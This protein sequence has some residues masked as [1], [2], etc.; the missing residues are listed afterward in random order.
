[1]GI[2]PACVLP[3]ALEGEVAAFSP[4]YWDRPLYHDVDLAFFKLVGGG[5]ARS[6]SLLDFLNP[7][8]RTQRNIR[9]SMGAAKALAIDGNMVGEHK[10]LKGGLAVLDGS[11]RAVYTFAEDKF[12]DHA[13]HEEILAACDRV[14]S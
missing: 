4:E 2:R 10:G 1:M 7:F 9:R 13:P 14:K 11:G 5:Q 8:G 6:G 12:G 3:E